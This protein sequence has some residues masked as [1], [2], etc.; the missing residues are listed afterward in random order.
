[1]T[2]THTS[3]CSHIDTSTHARTL[4]GTHAHARTCA[5]MSARARSYHH[6]A[7]ENGAIR[8]IK[9]AHSAARCRHSLLGQPDRAGSAQCITAGTKRRPRHWQHLPG[10]ARRGTFRLGSH[11]R[12][13]DS[14]NLTRTRTRP[15]FLGDNCIFLQ[16]PEVTGGPV[17][18]NPTRTRTGPAASDGRRALHCNGPA[19]SVPARLGFRPSRLGFRLGATAARGPGTIAAQ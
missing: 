17:R 2:S 9:R 7:L 5:C 4:T 18:D 11:R 13:R 12:V 15:A 16:M 3:R 19:R 10:R 8:D 6:I 14:D 1:M